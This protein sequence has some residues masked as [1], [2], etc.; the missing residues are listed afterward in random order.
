MKNKRG[1][2]FLIAA[3]VIVVI[4]VSV[5]TISNY[6]QTGQITHIEDLGEEID[7]ESSF[8]L[9][10]GASKDKTHNEMDKIMELFIDNYIK[11]MD[12]KN[13]YFIFGDSQQ[14]HVRGYQMLDKGECA[15]ITLNNPS[16]NGKCQELID[17]KKCT[18]IKISNETNKITQN[19]TLN[20]QEINKVNLHLEI[21]SYED[22]ISP[23]QN[24]YFVIKGNEGGQTKVVVS[25]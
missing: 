21:N 22:N 7:I 2:F 23:G 5:L 11:E 13:V 1:Q 6:T 20:G 9:D 14:I 25:K 15:C 12:N 18:P 17:S 19:L 8:V 16:L 10:Y 24:F 3:I 4:S